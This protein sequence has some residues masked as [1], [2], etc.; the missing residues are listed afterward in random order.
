[1]TVERMLRLMAGFVVMASAALAAFHSPWWLCLTGF[2]GLNLF[3]SA[4]TNW[5]PAVWMFEKL[6][7]ERAEPTKKAAPATSEPAASGA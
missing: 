4:F 5:C 7:F 3:Q 1:M 2:A 6:G